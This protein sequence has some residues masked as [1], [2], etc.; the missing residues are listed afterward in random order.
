MIKFICLTVG[1]AFFA[2]SQLLH[3]AAPYTQITESH[4]L[5]QQAQK[6]NC[7]PGTIL[8]PPNQQ[9]CWHNEHNTYQRMSFLTYILTLSIQRT[10]ND[11][12]ALAEVIS[13]FRRQAHPQQQQ[14]YPKFIIIF[15]DATS[16]Q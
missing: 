12:K 2:F 13:W 10:Q 8:P 6:D 11:P 3:S 4:P 15:P 16:Q 1:V 5:Q 7:F 14:C 9:P